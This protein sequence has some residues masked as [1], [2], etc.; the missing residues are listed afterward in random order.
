MISTSYYNYGRYPVSN[1]EFRCRSDVH[2]PQYDK[3]EKL[4]VL[5]DLLKGLE[6]SQWYNI[7]ILGE[8][9]VGKSTFINAFSNYI[10]FDSLDRAMAAKGPL[11]YVI[12]TTFSYEER[13]G[14]TSKDHVVRVG[15]DTADENHS[16]TRQ[17]ATQR[18][19]RYE[20][21]LGGGAGSY[22][23]DAGRVDET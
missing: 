4:H 18:C 7:L 6:L 11:H 8:P 10:R 12:P 15:S 1:A 22:V 2:R 13:G 19:K 16:S 9:G 21:R 14:E 17:S 23:S 3:F 20:F 5:E